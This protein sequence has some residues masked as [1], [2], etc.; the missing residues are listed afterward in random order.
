MVILVTQRQKK[1]KP[2]FYGTQNRGIWASR[3]Q[4]KRGTLCAVCRRTLYVNDWFKRIFF[5]FV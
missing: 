2:V 5:I 3:L 1:E 4:S